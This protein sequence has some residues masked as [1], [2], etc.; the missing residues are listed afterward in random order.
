MPQD[1]NLSDQIGQFESPR[2]V[3]I[4]R[5]S[6]L[7][8][9]DS[10][11]GRWEAT[12]S[13]LGYIYK[14]MKN[15]YALNWLR[16]SLTSSLMTCNY[17]L[18]DALLFVVKC[19]FRDCALRPRCRA[20]NYYLI[21]LCAHQFQMFTEQSFYVRGSR[22]QR[23]GGRC[24]FCVAAVPPSSRALVSR[25]LLA[26]CSGQKVVVARSPRSALSSR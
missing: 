15:M 10:K 7:P 3:P 22:V 21:T 20:D 9:L 8:P 5:I 6:V 2:C 12:S 23:V 4:M 11:E 19:F 25:E 18:H 17:W 24:A 26:F 16:C 1:L 13:G 14:R